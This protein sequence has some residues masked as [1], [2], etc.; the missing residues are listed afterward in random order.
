MMIVHSFGQ[1]FE[2]VPAGLDR[3]APFPRTY[4]R[5]GGWSMT[6][7]QGIL[8]VLIVVV[9]LMVSCAMVFSSSE[10]KQALITEAA[11]RMQQMKTGYPEVGELVKQG[12]D[13]SLFPN[14]GKGGLVI[15]AAYGRGVVYEQGQHIGYSDLTHGS[16]GL[17]AGGQTFSELLVFENKTALERFKEGKLN[18][19]ADASAVVLKTGVATNASFVNGVAVVVSPIGGAMLEAAIGGQQFTY[20]QK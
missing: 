6:S 16:V 10:D 15:G 20:Q 3:H 9:G 13:Y 19:A 12:Y 2:R 8:L 18:F 11:T 17:Q 5:D 14:V 4:H 7:T 1:P